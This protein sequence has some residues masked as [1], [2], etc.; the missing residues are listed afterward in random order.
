M[1]QSSE[2]LT[3][4]VINQHRLN[5]LLED[6]GDEVVQR[7]FIIYQGEVGEKIIL[8][9]RHLDQGDFAAVECESHALK[10]ASTNLGLDQVGQ[11]MAEMEQAAMVR[12]H[13]GAQLSLNQAL[14]YCEIIHKMKSL[15]QIDAPVAHFSIDR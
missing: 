1:A 15:G 8:I 4:L 9:S 11:V 6:L 2:P 12:D 14:K 10:S 5:S 7:L 13:K 3:A